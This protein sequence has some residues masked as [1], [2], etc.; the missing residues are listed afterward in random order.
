MGVGLSHLL[1]G[2][3]CGVSPLNPATDARDALLF[4]LVAALA[5][6]IPALRVAWVEPAG[7]PRED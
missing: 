6:P 3:L 1:A 5:S 4:L 2:M 7:I